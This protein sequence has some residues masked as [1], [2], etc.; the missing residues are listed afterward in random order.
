M[1]ND[2][3]PGPFPLGSFNRG[4]IP[5]PFF[6]VAN[7][8]MPRNFKEVLRWADYITTQSPT[9]AE[10]IRKHATYPIT[11][12]T[13]ETSNPKLEEKYRSL[14]KSLRLKH[15]L[16]TIGFDFYTRG[17]V[18]LSM[19]MPFTRMA[20]CPSCSTSY[21]VARSGNIKFK[22]F[23]FIGSC[24]KEGCSHSGTFEIHDVF[25]KSE[26]E[27]NI[28]VWDPNHITVNHNPVTGRSEHYYEVPPSVRKKVMLGDPLFTSS[29]PLAMIECIKEKKHFKFDEGKIFHMSNMSIG[30]LEDG[31]CIPPIM[32][33]YSLVFHQAMLRKANEAIATEHM[34]PMRVLFPQAGTGNGDPMV[35]LSLGNFVSNMEDNLKRFKQDP[36]RAVISPV[37]VGYQA[38]GGEG[39]N[40]LV[41]QELQLAE[42][43]VLMSLGV[44]RELM[45][46][47]TNWTSSTVGL[48]LLRNT[49]ENY[50][51]QLM[52]VIDWVFDQS[53]SFLGVERV[54]VGL[55]PFQL[56][57]DDLLKNLMPTLLSSNL[58]SNTTA[59]ASVGIDFN[60]ELDNM[61]REAEARERMK[62][63]VDAAMTR[64]R[65][66]AAKKEQH[67][68]NKDSTLEEAKAKAFD[69]FLQ[70]SAMDPMTQQSYM[71]QLHQQDPALEG[72][73]RELME[74]MV[75]QAPEPDPSQQAPQRGNPEGNTQ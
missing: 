61:K 33:I 65:F 54:K 49:M 5:N 57:D 19:Y 4:F 8:F 50:V 35:S 45:A 10:V 20:K 48:R 41:A 7:Q 43:S 12:F 1:F 36:N 56:T 3:A 62:V 68:D 34:T 32:S 42:E 51:R 55:T 60:K 21:N 11:D 26:S 59:L 2:I 38:I 14:V 69:L 73:L 52:E 66:E 67:K 24:V 23:T 40:L 22:N 64:A 58:I 75:A 25:S 30:R 47:T 15:T 28:V 70:L 13:F 74:K 71:L 6:T 16:N 9:A 29:L 63:E 46:G 37:P 27:M 44:S 39:K 31:L 18:F 17:N 53:T 72:L